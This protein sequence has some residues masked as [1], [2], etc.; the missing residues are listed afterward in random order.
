MTARQVALD[1]VRMN[2]GRAILEVRKEKGLKQETIALDAGT[3][4]GHLSRI[5]QGSR[6]PSLHMLE[7]LAMALGVSITELVSRAE[8]F[9]LTKESV[10]LD[11]P[12]GLERLVQKLTSENRRLAVEL[13]RALLRVQG[14]E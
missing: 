5:E 9:P 3:N 2:I 8:G 11:E 4:T 13:I 12:L 6:Q 10:P 14:N 7:R 1:N